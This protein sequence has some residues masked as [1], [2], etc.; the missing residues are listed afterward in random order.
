[1]LVQNGLF[2][3]SPREP[4]VAVSIELLTLYQY[5]LEHS[6]TSNSAFCSALQDFYLS[7]G[8]W[9]LDAKVCPLEGSPSSE[10]N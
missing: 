2:P 9:M 7:W 3:M 5:L 4:H 10:A 6:G 1:V 8:F